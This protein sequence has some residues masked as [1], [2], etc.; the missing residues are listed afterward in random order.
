MTSRPKTTLG[1][2]VVAVGAL[3]LGA[4]GSSSSADSGPG[5]G[6]GA[7]TVYNAQHESLTKEWVDAFTKQTGVKVTVRNGSDTELSNQIVQEG[8]A[9]PADVFLTENSP[10]MTQVENAGLFADVDKATL[11]QV[12]SAF[13]PSTGKWTGIAARS[14][15]LVY[16]K[17]KLREDQLP[18]SM[19]DLANPEWKGRWA[20]SPSGADFQAIV[21][22][23]LELKGE[24]ATAEWLKGMKE[25]SK[26]YKGNSTAMK[27]VNAGEVD[28]ALIYHYYYYGDQAKTG[29]NSKNVTPYYFKNQDP[30]AFVSIS[31]GGVLKSSK[32]AA[33]AQ[34]FLKFI[35]GKKGQEVLQKGT[36][37]EYAIASDV[38]SNDK[39][40]PLKELQAPTVDPA[41]LNSAK[42]TELMTQAGLL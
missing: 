33:A 41:K 28:A 14:T 4:C 38:P 20:A 10:A 19:L 24:A 18:K 1:L 15:V 21:S 12:P 37:F 29:E 22:A 5:S 23:L 40:V 27:A 36:S 42:V 26:A 17:A 9:S 8:E 7:I 16:D 3:A 2:A 30:G 25:N 11:D 13:R 35:T 34:S 32:N 6:S 31:G 39:L